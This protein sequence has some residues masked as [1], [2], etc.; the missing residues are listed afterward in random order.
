MKVYIVY[1][2]WGYEGCSEPLF[3]FSSL[4]L[5]EKYVMERKIVDDFYALEIIEKIVDHSD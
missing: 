5:A 4:S 3:V 1:G 2:D